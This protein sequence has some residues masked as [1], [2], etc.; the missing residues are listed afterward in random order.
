MIFFILREIKICYA[1]TELVTENLQRSKLEKIN[2]KLLLT[3]HMPSSPYHV[4]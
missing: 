3:L 4:V 2:A 1:V